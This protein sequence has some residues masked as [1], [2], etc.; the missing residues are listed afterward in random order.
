MS[1][2]LGF[3]TCPCYCWVS[4]IDNSSF[5]HTWTL[6]FLHLCS[7]PGNTDQTVKFCTWPN[8]ALVRS[9]ENQVK[10]QITVNLCDLWKTNMHMQVSISP[11]IGF[12]LYIWLWNGCEQTVAFYFPCLFYVQHLLHIFSLALTAVGDWNVIV[13]SPFWDIIQNDKC[14]YMDC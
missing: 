1:C 6:E 10:T 2:L 5:V 4:I 9:D 12:V 11:S 14:H 7:F 8:V 13:A 3:I